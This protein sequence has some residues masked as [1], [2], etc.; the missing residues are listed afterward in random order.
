MFDLRPLTSAAVTRALD[1]RKTKFNW[2]QVFVS[3]RKH[4]KRMWYLLGLEEI[5]GKQLI[6]NTQ[7]QSLIS[8]PQFKNC[9]FK[10]FC[11]ILKRKMQTDVRINFSNAEVSRNMGAESVFKMKYHIMTDFFRRSKLNAYPTIYNTY[12]P[13]KVHLNLPLLLSLLT[14]HVL[15]AHKRNN[16]KVVVP[17]WT[18]LIT[19]PLHNGISFAL[20]R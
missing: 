5:T 13:Q 17:T 16:R 12:T 10:P 19:M 9:T 18:T 11:S 15:S 7:L 2:I 4:F 1:S 8:L 6:F 20:Q 14:S 3:I